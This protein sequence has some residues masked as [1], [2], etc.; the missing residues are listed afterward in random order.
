MRRHLLSSVCFV[1]SLW[2]VSL[3]SAS[4]L[5]AQTDQEVTA[6]RLKGIEFLKSQQQEDGSWEFEGHPVGITALCTLA[7][8]ENGI[9]VSDSVIQKGRAFVVKESEK[10][11]STYDLA[12][13]ILLLSR[14]GDR[15][16]KLLIRRF[17]AR[18]IAG[19][20]T[21]GGWSYTCPL[22]AASSLNNPR[23]RL[24]LGT[25]PGD[26]SCTQFAVLGLWTAS[27]SNV[28]I[29]DSMSGVAR[30]F[31]E[32]QNE[33]GGWPY[34]LSTDDMKEPS[35]N[36]MTLAGLFCLTVARATKIRSL[37][38]EQNKVEAAARGAEQKEGDTLVS[39]PIF[40]KGLEMAGK[41]AAGISASSA[42]Y[43]LW[44]TERVGVLLGLEKLGDTDWFS[45]GA[46]AL[47]ATQKEDGSWEDSRGKLADT[48]FAILFLRKANLGSDISRM[49]NGEP[50]KKFQIHSQAKK[51]EFDSLEA[52]I[53]A[54]KPGDLIRV[55]GDGPFR[56][57]HV[58]VDKDLSIEAG[59][60]YSP[61]FEYARGRN[62]LG[63]RARP[64]RDPNVRHILQ[65]T[66]GTLALEGIR[67]EFDP[68]EVGKEVPWVAIK[69]DGGNLRMLNCSVSEQNDKGM[70][71]VQFTRP[72]N[73]SITNSFFVGGRAAFEIEGTGK[74]TIDVDESVIF[75]RKIFSVLKSPEKSAGGSI[76]LNLSRCTIQ[77]IDGF[78]FE[79]F[80]KD[81]NVKSDHCAW[82]VENLGLSMLSQRGAKTD[83]SYTGDGNVYDVDVWLGLNGTADSSVKDLKS[84]NSFWGNTDETSLADTLAFNLRRVN[85][86]FNHRYTPADWEL[87]ETSRVAA[88]V[89]GL[90]ARTSNVGAGAGFSRFR[91]SILYNEWKEK[92]VAEAK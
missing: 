52:A 46:A 42:R 21:T 71:A 17:A 74:Q 78:V 22:A 19:Q 76:N 16:D 48:S 15:E 6:S 92:Q 51:P 4:T 39:D 90:G 38:E 85:T 30:R 18:L 84:W 88:Q 82:K 83:R 60:G 68:P 57:P 31:V 91:S 12:L 55:N 70:A 29:D 36:S 24:K 72:T 59:F 14:I 58:T 32:T 49:L 20:S 44:S 53:A 10:L 41:Y 73:S 8:L 45:K 79:R 47:I 50:A 43:F 27:R 35:R 25:S 23:G 80:V 37:Q 28:N 56:I 81:I 1:S 7:L 33:D 3:I 65:V 89:T 2:A 61:V 40:A 66:K 26:N 62:K 34:K 77:G 87:S 11:N 64:E 69:V 13:A 86:S 5:Q 75:S 54:A 67:F 63:L 9:P